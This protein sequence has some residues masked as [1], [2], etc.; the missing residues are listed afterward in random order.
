MGER[1]GEV[2][3]VL[4]L[5][6]NE[7]YLA[8]GGDEPYRAELAEDVAWLAG[9]MAQLMPDATECWGLLALMRLHLARAAAS[10]TPRAGWCGLQDQDRARWNRRMIAEAI[11]MLDRAGRMGRPGPYQLQAAIAA[12]HA[13]TAA[14]EATDW[15][16]V[17]ALYDALLGYAESPV[18]RLNRAV[19]LS[20]LAGPRSR[21]RSWPGCARASTATTSTTRPGAS[22][23]TA[24]DASPRRRQPGAPLELTEQPRRAAPVEG[25][26]DACSISPRAVRPDSDR[27]RWLPGEPARTGGRTLMAENQCSRDPARPHRGIWA[28][29]SGRVDLGG[30]GTRTS[31]PCPSPA[32]S[33]RAP[34]AR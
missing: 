34:R 30:R 14:F 10:S 2:L 7:G 12:C 1:L 15:A 13:E 4:Y 5:M 20:H 32:P 31:C 9:L 24:W 23:W 25:Q 22:C 11:R 19:A 18:V 26:V 28:I 33:P 17:V 21:W 3:A 6:F 16:Q 8:S 29:W 27:L